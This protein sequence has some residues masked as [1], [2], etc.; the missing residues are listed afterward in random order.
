MMPPKR[1][2][3]FP[4]HKA[5]KNPLIQKRA[6]TEESPVD[7][8]DT[9]AIEEVQGIVEKKVERGKKH[10]FRALKK[11][12]VLEKLKLVKRLKIAR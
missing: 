12:K 7:L 8:S 5:R 6:E 4:S 10:V 1:K 2:N 11:M 9:L 3:P